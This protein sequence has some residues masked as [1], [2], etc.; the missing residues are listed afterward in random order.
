MS[1][2]QPPSSEGLSERDLANRVNGGKLW[3][4]EVLS[5]LFPDVEP[6][7]REFA[8]HLHHRV[9]VPHLWCFV[10]PTDPV[11][12]IAIPAWPVRQI[13]VDFG[14]LHEMAHLFTADLWPDQFYKASVVQAEAAALAVEMLAPAHVW[15]SA[16]EPNRQ[17]LYRMSRPLIHDSRVRATATRAL[18]S[19]LPPDTLV[20]A[21]LEGVFDGD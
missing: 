12:R 9:D 17:A 13:D 2:R 15:M 4:Y 3:D 6:T 14:F 10:S 1:D 11:L 20:R 7:D 5:I 19:R 8:V 18:Q 16:C 21:V